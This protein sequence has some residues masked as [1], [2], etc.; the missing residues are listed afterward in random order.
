MNGS[1]VGRYP[2]WIGRMA[3]S[4][5]TAAFGR[6]T[7]NG[8]HIQ[9]ALALSWE[10]LVSVPGYEAQACV[11]EPSGT[12]SEYAYQGTKYRLLFVDSGI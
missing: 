4:V 5:V 3:V 8:R 9:I 6:L 1:R 10:V 11:P 7:W 2:P 12:K